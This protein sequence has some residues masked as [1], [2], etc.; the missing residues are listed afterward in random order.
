MSS[1]LVQDIQGRLAR[2]LAGDSSLDEFKDWLVGETWEV[3]QRADAEAE[4]LTYRIKHRLAEQSGGHITE[5][6]LRRTLQPLVASAP[7]PPPV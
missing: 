3:E 4:K 1:P 7:A 5:D 6:A 2:Y